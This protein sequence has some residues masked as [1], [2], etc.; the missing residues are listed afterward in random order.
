MA[1]KPKKKKTDEE[2]NGNDPASKSE[3]DHGKDNEHT[4]THK[5]AE[6]ENANESLAQRTSVAGG[7]IGQQVGLPRPLS[8]K[9]A[10][11]AGLTSTHVEE[12]EEE[13]ANE[14]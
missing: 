7:A 14:D 2:P 3:V 11:E 9:E 10:A 12:G 6:P 5:V 4:G 1:R 8:A 13:P